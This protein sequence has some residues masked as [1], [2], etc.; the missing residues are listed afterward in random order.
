VDELIAVE[1]LAQ[2]R[3]MGEL[4]RDFSFDTISGAGPN[5]AIV[6]Y[7]SSPRTNRKLQAGELFLLDSG[8]QYLDGTT[9]ITRTIAIGT[10]TPEMRD[11]FTRVLKGHIALGAAKFPRG[12]SGSQLDALARRALWEVGLDYDHGTGHGVG[13]YLAVHEG[14]HR[15]SKV[16]NRVALLPGMIVSNEPGYYKTGAYGIRVENLVAVQTE[17]VSEGGLPMLS[18]ETLT[19]APID[20]RLVDT[21]IMTADEIAWLDAYHQRVRESLTPLLDAPTATWLAQAT[22]PLGA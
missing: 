20:L 4:F 6:H 14:P 19:M 10:P 8:A 21:K 5:G 12:T 1:K 11:R 7:R 2:F 16:P 15:I 3:R 18:F 9:D 22:R 13:S 17:P